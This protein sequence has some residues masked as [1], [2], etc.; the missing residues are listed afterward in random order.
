MH[1]E[2]AVANRVA[3]SREAFAA[4]ARTTKHF[5]D[6]SRAGRRTFATNGELR[7]AWPAKSDTRYAAANFVRAESRFVE[8]HS[9]GFRAVNAQQRERQRVT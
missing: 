7:R 9:L 6:A 3:P 4:G 1:A 8:N 2:N 5:D